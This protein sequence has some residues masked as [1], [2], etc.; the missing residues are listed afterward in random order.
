MGVIP[1]P[2]VLADIAEQDA[3]MEYLDILYLIYGRE[4]PGHPQHGLYTGLVA[5]RSADLLAADRQ[6]VASGWQK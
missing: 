6:A 5:K 4:A 1:D 2:A 3:R